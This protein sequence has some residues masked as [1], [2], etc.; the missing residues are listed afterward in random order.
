M[1]PSRSGGGV[2]TGSHPAH[3]GLRCG[4][5]VQWCRERRGLREGGLLA[6]W[7]LGLVCWWEEGESASPWEGAS[8]AGGASAGQDAAPLWPVTRSFRTFRRGRLVN[9]TEAGTG[10]S[11]SQLCRKGKGEGTVTVSPGNF[12]DLRTPRGLQRAWPAPLLPGLVR[13]VVGRLF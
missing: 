7:V 13:R 12:L 9:S 5:Q 8:Q 10:F 2:P 1:C 3:S 6:G 11:T 4:S